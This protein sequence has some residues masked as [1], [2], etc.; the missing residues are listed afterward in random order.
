M[1]CGRLGR[2]S[3]FLWYFMLTCTTTACTA[4]PSPGSMPSEP[5]VDSPDSSSATPRSATVADNDGPYKDRTSGF[6]GEAVRIEAD[7]PIRLGFGYSVLAG[8]PRASALQR[9]LESVSADAFQIRYSVDYAESSKELARTLGIKMSA[10]GSWGIG[11]VSGKAS[12]TRESRSHQYSGYLVVTA[13]ALRKTEIV[14]EARFRSEAL[15]LLEASPD[16]FYATYGDAFVYRKGW[17]AAL[18]AVLEVKAKRYETAEEFAAKMRASQGTFSASTEVRT[19]LHSKL[20]DRSVRIIY[21]QRGGFHGRS[22]CLQPGGKGDE[23]CD[24]WPPDNPKATGSPSRGGVLA[25]TLEELIVRLRDFG[26]EVWEHPEAADL[27]YFDVLDYSA[28]P[29]RGEAKLYDRVQTERGMEELGEIL[30][31]LRDRLED[32]RFARARRETRFGG[33]SAADSYPTVVVTDEIYRK[34]PRLEWLYSTGLEIVRE[35]LEDRSR[36]VGTTCLEEA[37]EFYETTELGGLLTDLSTPESL[38]ACD[39]HPEL[40]VG[41]S[42]WNADRWS[43]TLHEVLSDWRST[44]GETCLEH[45]LNRW[46]FEPEGQIR[47][48]RASSATAEPQPTRLSLES[49]R[50]F[51]DTV[52]YSRADLERELEERALYS[53][54]TLPELEG[55]SSSELLALREQAKDSK[56]C[57]N[58]A[59]AMKTRPD[60]LIKC[61]LAHRLTLGLPQ[62]P[63]E[64]CKGKNLHVEQ[65]PR[66]RV[67][68]KGH[69]SNRRN[70]NRRAAHIVLTPP[71]GMEVKL[72]GDVRVIAR[73]HESRVYREYGAPHPGSWW[74][75]SSLTQRK[76]GRSSNL[77]V[78]VLNWRK[79]HDVD[80]YLEVRYGLTPAR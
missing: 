61:L 4:W 68:R 6:H 71:K 78:E 55:S 73:V 15:E 28:I 63:D 43:G 47:G 70:A 2:T 59:R 64:A 65:S 79:S 36:L 31:T 16:R 42:V 26:R 45:H 27:L 17:G 54:M 69:N 12:L 50:T 20:N 8:A 77:A 38:D 57:E 7:G 51:L 74:E 11:S 44:D 18:T 13:E 30:F 35:C 10:K 34:L 24:M 29:N 14:D 41:A 46:A 21:A 1:I 53:S 3:L 48:P 39:L 62:R 22:V 32:I 49:A 58:E 33:A 25:L 76:N 60:D 23:P 67:P 52:T 5:A 9:P 40:E 37:R 72:C 75:I 80:F 56:V 66:V 19:S